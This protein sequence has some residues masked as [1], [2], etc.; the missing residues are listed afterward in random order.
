MHNG[1]TETLSKEFGLLRERC[2]AIDLL[3]KSKTDAMVAD[4]V[5]KV[6]K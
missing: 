5:I 3:D 6:R 2:L 4:M 1:H